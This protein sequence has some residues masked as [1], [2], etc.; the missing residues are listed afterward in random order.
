M[1]FDDFDCL[2]DC[3]TLFQKKKKM[4]SFSSQLLT[5]FDRIDT[6]IAYLLYNRSKKLD[7]SKNFFLFFLHYNV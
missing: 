3:P 2:I 5:G 4:K 6:P 7:V 1:N